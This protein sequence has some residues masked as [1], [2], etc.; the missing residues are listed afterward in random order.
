MDTTYDVLVIGAGHAG[1][2]AALASARLGAK[3][4]LVTID[5]RAIA[6]M[7]CNPSIGGI[8]KSHMVHELD[9]LG[10]E[11][12]RNADYTGIQFRTLN[13][14][15]GPAVQAGRVQCDKPAFSERMIAIVN[16]Q[17]NLTVIEALVGELWIENG[18]LRGIRTTDGSDIT[19]KTVVLTTGTFL[20]GMIHIGDVA[21]PGGRQ[22]EKAAMELS[23]SIL[24]LGLRMERMKT[25]T[26]PR[27]HRDSIDYS[28]MTPQPGDEPPPL[29]SRQAQRE[30]DMFHV[31]QS[32]EGT[33]DY[34]MFHVEQSNDP[35]RPWPPGWGQMPCFLAETNDKTHAIIRDNLERSSMYG[36][37]IQGT[38]VRYCPSI[39]DKIVKFAD[40]SSHH[41]FVEPE[42]RNTL[43]IYPNGLSNSLPEEIQDQMLRTI[44]GFENTK[45]LQWGYAIEYD[46]CDPT[47]LLHTLESKV[48]EGLYFAG[49]INGTTG[50]EEAGGQGFVAGANAALKTLKRDPLILGRGDSYI[51]V[52]IDDLVTKGTDEPYRMFTSRAEHRLL[53]RQDNARFRLL[54]HASSLGILHTDDLNDTR[55]FQGE[56]AA[57]RARLEKTFEGQHA[58]GQLLRRPENTYASLDGT[59]KDLDPVVQRQV[60]VEVK[61]AGY[62]KRE[63]SQILKA[64][65]FEKVSIP[66]SLD[67]WDIKAL[68]YEAREK[69]DKV[70]PGNL[71]QAGRV[72]GISPAD[73][74]ILSVMLKRIKD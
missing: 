68:S 70:R 12:G 33:G 60:E 52:L 47:Q 65:G 55:R 14:K 21:K 35:I 45:V 26:P 9:A 71:G 69:L 10:G 51:G 42:G 74:A 13:T 58:I 54:E 67:Y 41:I 57:E 18:K 7:S 49:Q 24:G 16:R 11:M 3:T 22:G 29:F 61:Y 15:K 32:G 20:R 62:I 5:K 38:G 36:G 64:K 37:A 72:P 4:G 44:P 59:R 66:P 40:K 48:V 19:G 25:G 17:D 30:W 50:Y 56:I 6:R 39:E 63:E 34:A 1:Y 73:L 27:L 28:K 31:E 46:Y 53:L 2:E 23:D 8:A 43:E